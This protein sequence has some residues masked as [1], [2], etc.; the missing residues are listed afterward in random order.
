MTQYDASSSRFIALAVTFGLASILAVLMRILARRRSKAQ[1]GV[2]DV[3]AVVAMCGFLAFLVVVVW[4]SVA[5]KAWLLPL[6]ALSESY[7]GLH[8]DLQSLPPKVLEN[9]L[10]VPRS[11]GTE[12]VYVRLRLQG[13]YISGIFS[14]VPGAAGRFS[15]LCLYNRVF[16]T[17]RS[18]YI[19]VRILAIVNGLWYVGCTVALLLRCDPP[20]KAWNP[21]V[22][23][24]CINADA[25]VIAAEIPEILLDFS[26]MILPISVL[27][28]LQLSTRRKINIAIIFAVGGL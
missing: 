13:L 26:M 16:N 1:L 4:G 11:S 25:F 21:L 19:A 3:F 27:R 24:H 18:F 6:T 17:D 5:L 28:R 2:D 22:T 20:R 7:N 15:L 10:K 8:Y 14:P 9:L 12:K 23:G